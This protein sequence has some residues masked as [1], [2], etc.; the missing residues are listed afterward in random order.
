MAKLLKISESEAT[1]LRGRS[2]TAFDRLN[3]ARKDR[4]RFRDAYR[5]E[6]LGNEKEGRCNMI[7]SDVHDRVEAQ[8]PLLMRR[9]LATDPRITF[10]GDDPEVCKIAKVLCR[11]T[12]YSQDGFL[13]FTDALKDAAICDI[14]V[15]K[16][17]W[18]RI[19]GEPETTV[20][21]GEDDTG[22][23]ADQVERLSQSKRYKILQLVEVTGP[24]VEIP[25]PPEDGSEPE[26]FA[27][28]TDR[29][30]AV[31]VK[32]R[33]LKE[34]GPV[35]DPIP[36]EEFIHEAGKRRMND[37][38]AVY[39]IRKMLVGEILREQDRLST[40]DE[41]YYRN[42]DQALR[43][44]GQSSPI[45]H[46]SEVELEAEER[47]AYH[48]DPDTMGD[49][50]W[51]SRGGELNLRDEKW[52]TEAYDW[53]AS[54]GR[55]VQAVVTFI[56]KTIVRC[57]ENEDGIVP[58]SAWSPIPH[59]HSI[60]GAG[61]GRLHADDQDYNTMLKRGF[62]DSVGFYVDNVLV[63]DPAGGV[64]E[65]SLEDLWPGKVVHGKKDAISPLRLSEPSTAV[66]T[67]I[68]MNKGDADE[69]GTA[70]RMAGMGTDMPQY[71][72]TATA[73]AGFQRASLNRT[74]LVALSFAET[75]LADLYTKVF[76]LFQRHMDKPRTVKIDG[77]EIEVTREML[78]GDYRAKAEIGID[79]D[80]DDRE[81]AKAS[82]MLQQ[83]MLVAQRYP[84]L[85]PPQKM[86]ELVRR[87]FV[88][89]GEQAVTELMEL[90]P[91]A[92]TA[93]PPGPP[94]AP[95]GGP[96]GLLGPGEIPPD[97][98]ADAM[99]GAPTAQ[100]NAALMGI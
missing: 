71:N 38:K 12:I 75:F 13:L 96:A 2:S 1:V 93:P 81:A 51:E 100:P 3:T 25:A 17:Y 70:T 31:V 76:F 77:K 11:E 18:R 8:H 67:A 84:Q 62:L 14:G 57:E 59:P 19:W 90:D 28:S 47:V 79:V 40:P 42:L 9:F 29:K 66:L 39:H 52:V 61:I 24:E 64:D 60:V 5:R 85:F 27:I 54:G 94:G 87:V 50:G 44:G 46:V 16:V 15:A 36:S 83:A 45:E 98:G 88:A 80:F 23:T 65:M 43:D 99:M 4:K 7:A 56:G 74:D 82:A 21:L 10:V 92:L 63:V 20:M 95:P 49:P 72:K 34:S 68:E 97:A 32:H 91:M 89:Y 26:E 41:P 86:A 53:V 6:P 78:E 35:I 22:M 48:Y 33:P 73:F 58:F 69:R 30:Y 55:L 37:R